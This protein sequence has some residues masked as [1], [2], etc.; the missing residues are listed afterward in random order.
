MMRRHSA[1]CFLTG[2]SA[3][4][5]SIL[6]LSAPAQAQPDEDGDGFAIGIIPTLLDSNGVAISDDGT[7]AYLSSSYGGITVADAQ[8][9]TY[10]TT[11]DISDFIVLPTGI[12][13]S[14]E[15]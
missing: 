8:T 9:L 7:R 14:G 4:L 11:F 13:I 2:M 3:A 10:I 5:L 12:A 1:S 6:V 15:K